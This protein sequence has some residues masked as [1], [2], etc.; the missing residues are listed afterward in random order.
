MASFPA[1]LPASPD[2][3]ARRRVGEAEAEQRGRLP[4]DRRGL[5]E[6]LAGQD[7]AAPLRLLAVLVARVADAGAGDWMT[8]GDI[9]AAGVAA[10]VGLDMR[11]WWSATPASYLARVPKAAILAAVREDAARCLAGMK[12][13][14]MAEA[15]AAG[16]GRPRL[17]ARH[18]A[19]ARRG[20]CERRR[21]ATG[22]RRRVG[23]R[24]GRPER[25]A[26]PSPAPVRAGRH[27]RPARHRFP[28]GAAPPRPANV[29]PRAPVYR[30]ECH[31]MLLRQRSGCAP[32]PQHSTASR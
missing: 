9:V 22:P 30:P 10:A 17:A 13:E 23:A 19:R 5:W 32:H 20:G 16:P 2:S 1:H 14:P 24:L 4:A 11:R 7:E 6:W 12:K 26:L 15:A 28:G 25:T 21:R 27:R 31:P 8:P 18:A 29:V 3:P